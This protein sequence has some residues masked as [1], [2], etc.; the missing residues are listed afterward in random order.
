MHGDAIM[1]LVVDTLA[2]DGS[3]PDTANL[4]LP[5]GLDQL[6][7]LGYIN[8]LTSREVC[9]F[10]DDESRYATTFSMQHSKRF[11]HDQVVFQTRPDAHV[12]T[13]I[14]IDCDI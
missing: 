7:L 4:L 13:H 2:R 1:Q 6:T 8:S 14:N 10:Y 5:D 9:L 12:L 3:I 11:Q